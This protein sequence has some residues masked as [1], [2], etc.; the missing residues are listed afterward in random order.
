MSHEAGMI[1]EFSPKRE[2]RVL[3]DKIH[4]W[5]NL[6]YKWFDFLETFLNFF[7]YDRLKD[8]DLKMMF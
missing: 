5:S 2:I 4:E 8:I 3:I 1:H 7:Y 6:T